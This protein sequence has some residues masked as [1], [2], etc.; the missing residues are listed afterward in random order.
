MC[1][2]ELKKALYQSADVFTLQ[3]LEDLYSCVDDELIVGVTKRYK[4]F[5]NILAKET[6]GHKKINNVRLSDAKLFLIKIQ[7]DGKG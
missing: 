7:N 4:I 2:R 5:Q 3:D 6:F 1:S